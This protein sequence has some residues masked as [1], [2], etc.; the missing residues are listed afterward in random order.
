MKPKTSNGVSAVALSEPI[1]AQVL[2]SGT[3]DIVVA[4]VGFELAVVSATGIQLS[5]DG[6]HGG[7]LTFG[8]S[9]PVMGAV[10]TD[11]DGD[12]VLDLI[13][14]S[15]SYDGVDGKLWVWNPGPAGAMPW[16]AF[17]QNSTYRRGVV[18]GTNACPP[19]TPR[20]LSFY[21]LTPCRIVD[22]RQP[23]G[24]YTGPAL[25]AGETR[26]WTIAGQCG[27]PFAAR[28][29]VLNVTVDYATAPGDLRLYAGGESL[30]WA[31][32]IN[33]SAGQTRSNNA[34]IPLSSN[35]SGHMSAR[36]DQGAGTVHLIVDAYGYYQ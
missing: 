22:T 10:A 23:G 26:T 19:P 9:R 36:N 4:N 18:P 11:L 14:A 3:P 16:P 15:G 20:A 2:G 24:A 1:V 6:S 8:T 31:S 21:T 13:G 27:I 30:P 5:D 28:S 12:G 29:V 35:G 33:F 17:R 34:T 7:K 32:T 25:S